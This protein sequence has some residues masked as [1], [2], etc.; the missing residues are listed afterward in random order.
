M[1]NGFNAVG[2]I[3][4]CSVVL[5]NWVWA[6]YVLA[7]T[8]TTMRV[9]RTMQIPLDGRLLPHLSSS[10]RRQVPASA[11]YEAIVL[12]ALKCT[13]PA[14]TVLRGHVGFGHSSHIPPPRF[15]APLAGLR[16]GRDRRCAGEDRPPFSPCSTGMMSGGAS[17]TIEMLCPASTAPPTHTH[18]RITDGRY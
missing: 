9:G 5:S 1:A 11:L 10:A 6:G 16:C 4:R 3:G 14:R 8:S 2:N 7:A 15:P 17:S 18:S 12:K 13:S